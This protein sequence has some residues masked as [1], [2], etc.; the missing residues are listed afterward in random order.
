[1]ARH[2]CASCQFE[3]RCKRN[4]VAVAVMQREIPVYLCEADL[5]H[6][7]ICGYEIVTGIGNPYIHFS[8]LEFAEAEELIEEE[9]KTRPVIRSWANKDHYYDLMEAPSYA[10]LIKEE[11]RE[12]CHQQRSGCPNRR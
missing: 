1:M 8:S 6:C 10:G 9:G 5:W 7:P 12:N 4:G 11:K 3:M 2:V